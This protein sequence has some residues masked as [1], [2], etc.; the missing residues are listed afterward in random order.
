LFVKN[1]KLICCNHTIVVLCKH[2]RKQSHTMSSKTVTTTPIAITLD[3]KYDSYEYTFG[4]GM[5]PDPTNQMEHGAPGQFT[6]EKQPQGWKQTDGIVISGIDSEEWKRVLLDRLNEYL[7]PGT[8]PA[9]RV[10]GFDTA[11]GSK[12]LADLDTLK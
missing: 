7:P 9:T 8:A 1:V 12:V 5:Y 11:M 10:Y 2:T 3:M 6:F 4:D